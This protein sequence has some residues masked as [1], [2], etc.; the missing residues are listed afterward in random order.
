MTY[1][2][3][4][5]P[6]AKRADDEVARLTAALADAQAKLAALTTPPIT[7]PPLI[8]NP[9][10]TP[11][12][13]L[14]A[15]YPGWTRIFTEDFNTVASAGQAYS[16][17]A[18]AISGYGDSGNYRTGNVSAHDGMLDIA[19]PG[20][21][22][23]SAGTGGVIVIGPSTTR[24][25]RL[26]GRFSVRFKAVGASQSG[27]AFM[28]WPSSNKWSDGEIDYPEGSFGGN[29]QMFHH[30]TPCYPDQN[31]PV[32]GQPY[33]GTNAAWADTKTSWRDWHVASTEW[34]R[35]S[36]SYYLDGALIKT[37]TTSVPLTNHRFTI[38]AADSGAGVT[39][40]GNLLIDWVRI[41][42]LA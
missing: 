10:V 3:E 24:W 29:I 32:A 19:M 26:F 6:I 23:T 14:T 20:G 35:D 17:Y 15:V 25:A 2:D 30:P 11:V 38:Q 28:L 31:S 37:V 16:T 21:T 4:H 18:G 33:C 34:K 12:N 9:P 27:A 8:P 41:D 22:A 36:V 1:V 5:G 39:E 40:A 42:A 13:P 7:P